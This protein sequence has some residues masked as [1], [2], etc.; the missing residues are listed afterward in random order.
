MIG[1]RARRAH[2]DVQ[3]PDPKSK[4]PERLLLAPLDRL[5]QLRD[6]LLAHPLELGSVAA[7]VRP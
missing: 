2:S 4:P 5:E 1:Q 6:A 3:N 7:L